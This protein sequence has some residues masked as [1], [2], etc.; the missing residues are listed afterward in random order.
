MIVAKSFVQPHQRGFV[1]IDF[2]FDVSQQ[3]PRARRQRHGLVLGHGRPKV[4]ARR[5][6][7]LIGGQQQ[8]LGVGQAQD[9]GGHGL[10]H[11]RSVSL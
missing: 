2:G 7:G 6:L 3:R 1:D 11:W 10:G 5:A 9:S 8:V 4:H